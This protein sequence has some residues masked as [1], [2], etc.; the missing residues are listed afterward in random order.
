MYQI[1][2]NVIIVYVSTQSLSVLRN[3]VTET[4]AKTRMWKVSDMISMGNIPHLRPL[5]P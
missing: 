5:Y 2:K 1:I 3:T 4:D